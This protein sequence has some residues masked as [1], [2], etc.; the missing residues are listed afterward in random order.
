MVNK[1]TSLQPH[2]GNQQ[3][4][5]ELAHISNRNCRLQSFTVILFSWLLYNSRIGHKNTKKNSTWNLIAKF[6]LSAPLISQTLWIFVESA[7]FWRTSFPQGRPS[8]KWCLTLQLT[9]KYWGNSKLFIYQCLLDILISKREY[10]TTI[11]VYPSK[12]FDFF[13]SAGIY[14]MISKITPKNSK[15]CLHDVVTHGGRHDEKI[16]LSGS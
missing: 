10:L 1:S 14:I 6:W 16:L 3:V 7:N 15:L 11:S 12:D 13:L 9:T 2:G 8:V 5:S 4:C